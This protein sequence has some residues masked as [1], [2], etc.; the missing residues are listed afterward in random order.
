MHYILQTHPRYDESV[1]RWK[2]IDA[3]RGGTRTMREAGRDYL[4]QETGETANAYNVRLNRSFLFNGFVETVD[5]LTGKPLEQDI[6]LGE[7]TG[8]TL[9]EYAQNID[10]QGRNL[11]AFTGD[12]L[13]DA[14]Y[15]GISFIYVDMP[16]R[17]GVVSIAE[18][19]AKNIRPYFVHLKAGQVRNW[20]TEYV[21]GVETLRNVT[22]S[23]TEVINGEVVNIYKLVTP[24]SVESYKVEKKKVTHLSTVE[25]T[26]GLIPLVPIYGKRSGFMSGVPPLEN[27]AYTNLAHWQSASDQ[28]NIL[29]VSRVPI[30]LAT[31]FNADGNIDE[32]GNPIKGSS[33]I[34]NVLTVGANSVVVSTEAT[35][36]MRYV[37]HSGSAIGAGK[38]DLD[39]LKNEMLSQGAQFLIPDR[40]AKTATEYKGN[41]SSSESKL[42]RIVGN[43]QDALELCFDIAALWAE[44]DESADVNIYRDF[45]RDL[46]NPS[47]IDALLRARQAGLLTQETFLSELKRRNVLA[48]SLDIEVEAALSQEEAVI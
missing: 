23:T 4:P 10:L 30:L 12:V 7:K 27:L 2:L 35:A 3:L 33:E 36:N 18:Q 22:I 47:D 48:D 19:R 8:K 15:Y 31:G 16:A 46:G 11:T 5:M 14:L 28:R 17:E 29:R 34:D 39:D 6:M 43:L 44:I 25:H 41:K 38:Q 24:L 13:E 20:Q 9:S 42:Q 1:K 32:N 26:L 45:T 40:Q 21:N 37:E